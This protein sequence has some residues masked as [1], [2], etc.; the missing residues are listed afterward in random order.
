MLEQKI[1][2]SQRIQLD[3]L[4]YTANLVL[5]GNSREEIVTALGEALRETLSA[6][7][8]PERGNRNKAISILMKV[9][10]TVPKE[11]RMLRDEG[12]ELIQ[13]SDMKD[14]MLVHWCMCM[15]TYPFFGTVADAV[16]RLLRL[17]GSVGASQVQLRLRE[18]LG[19]RETVARAARR[20]LRVFIDWNTLLET[21]EKGLYYGTMKRPV[22]DP[23]LAIW[24]IVA[25]LNSMGGQPRSV[26]TL[27]HGPHLFPFEIALPSPRDLESCSTLE[28]IHHGLDQKVLIGL[29]V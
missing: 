17:Q 23:S 22:D 7:N 4:E 28:I 13:R 21:G 15:A 8:D 16:G 29:S 2:F 9:W 10:V 6:G 14:K 18:Q 26:T 20:I 11:L 19:E 5:A 12:L 27:L 1:G 25:V 24:A 3:W